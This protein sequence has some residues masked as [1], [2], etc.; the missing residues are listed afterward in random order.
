MR[1]LSYLGMLLFCLLGTLPLELYLKVGV[2]R[3]WRRLGLTLLGVVPLF[4]VWDL[5]AV[6]RGHWTF[7]PAQVLD[8]RLPGGLP[9]EEVAF[10]VVVPIAAVLTLEAVRQVR[11]WTVGDEQ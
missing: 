9:L 4:L 5:Y 11:G 6:H 10:F 8:V 2:Y 7:D 3:R 1:Q